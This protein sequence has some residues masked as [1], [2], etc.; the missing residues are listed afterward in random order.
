MAASSS[1][2]WLRAWRWD[3]ELEATIGACGAEP[4]EA[5]RRVDLI[6][7]L[8][9]HAGRFA[10]AASDP[11]Q[12]PALLEALW[13]DDTTRRLLRVNPHQ[14]AWWFHRESFEMLVR[15]LGSISELEAASDES[16]DAASR[17]LRSRA[18]RDLAAELIRSA[19]TAGYR[20]DRMASSIVR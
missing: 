1:R 13:P 16:H 14:D 11:A 12:I 3:R 9:T 10:G 19:A 5:S 18:S 15:W 4:R 6:D 20:V 2:Q 8:V 7:A 17:V